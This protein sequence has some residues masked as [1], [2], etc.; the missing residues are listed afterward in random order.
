MGKA[1]AADL[2]A[3]AIEAELGEPALVSLGGDVRIAAAD[4]EPWEVAVSEHPAGPAEQVVGLTD[5]GL[6][7]SST[8]VRRWSH[9]GVTR[10]HVL[11]P[12]TGRPAAEVWRTVTATGPSCVAANTAS[13]AAVV[14]GPDAPGWLDERRVA[15]R[16]VPR[17]RRR[18]HHRLA[19]WPTGGGERHDRRSRPLVPQPEHRRG[20]PRA[21]HRRPRCSVSSPSAAA[22]AAR[23]PRF[24]TQA[25]HRNLAL[26]GV[27]FLVVHVLAAVVDEFVEIRWWHAL[28]P[29]TSPYQRVWVGLGA[30]AVDLLVLVTVSSLLRSRMH[31]RGWRALHL[32]AYALWAT[33]ILHGGRAWAPT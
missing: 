14:L 28:V 5:G 10:H 19:G 1:W 23:V 24:V 15:A 17:P 30:V 21:A 4:G 29:F 25:V 18:R 8:R 11:D 3:A 9:R 27:L 12:R 16:L 13:T 7:T 20:G 33:S 32:T 2:V 22:R 31:H 6:A 26:L